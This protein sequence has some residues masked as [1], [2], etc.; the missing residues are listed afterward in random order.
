MHLYLII[1]N[2]FFK[3]SSHIE[4]NITDSQYLFC[5]EIKLEIGEI[6]LLYFPHCFVDEERGT[7]QKSRLSEKI[8]LG[9]S[10]KKPLAFHAPQQSRCAVCLYSTYLPS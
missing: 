8:H 9:K 5:D 3:I 10:R 7:I 6:S 2:C 1:E 4:L